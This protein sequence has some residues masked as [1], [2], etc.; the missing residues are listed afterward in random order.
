MEGIFEPS[1]DTVKLDHAS[2][3]EVNTQNS[4][5]ETLIS[6]CMGYSLLVLSRAMDSNVQHHVLG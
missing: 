2:N 1:S 6:I 4:K 3:L 5:L